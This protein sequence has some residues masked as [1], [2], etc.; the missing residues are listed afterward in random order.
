MKAKSQQSVAIPVALLYREQ[1][2]VYPWSN[3]G[4]WTES[5][6]YAEAAEALAQ[7]VGIAAKLQPGYRILDCAAGYG[8]SVVLWQQQ[9]SSAQV[10]VI[11]QQPRCLRFLRHHPPLGLTKV[12]E[13]DLRQLV[14]ETKAPSEID[15]YDALVS[16]DAAY[17]FGS[18]LDFFHFAALH[19]KPGGTLA[20]TTLGKGTN[21]P[22][23]ASFAAWI[24]R[25]FLVLAQISWQAVLSPKEIGAALQR[26]GFTEISVQDLN[27]PVLDGF[28]HFVGRR[29]RELSFRQRWTVAWGTITLTAAFARMVR[30]T[31]TLSYQLISA[32]RP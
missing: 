6:H 19:L 3:L 23:E 12:W 5:E 11:E 29:R 8:A 32:R 20:L 7:R 14:K 13:A 2:S 21:F 1:T 9:F 28:V 30:R 18:L 24:L 22:E 17:H 26:E 4:D 25:R 27:V 15:C 31:Q 10:D 16:V